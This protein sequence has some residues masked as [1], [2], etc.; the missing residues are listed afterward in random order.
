V[1]FA[2]A[3][4]PAPT[5]VLPAPQGRTAVPEVLHRLLLVRPQRPAVL[6]QLDRVRLAVDVPGEVL[7]RP[8]QLQQRLLDLPALGGVHGDRVRVEA[9]ADQGRDPLR[10]QDLLQHRTVGGGQ[11]QPVRRVLGQREPSVAVH[12]LG[13]VDQ[14]RVRHR[15]AA[16][17]HQRVHDLLGVVT[18]RARVPQA[19]WRHPVGVD[20]LRR[21]LQ[22]RERGDGPTAVVGLLVVDFQEQGLVGLDDQRTIHAWHP[23]PRPDGSDGFERLGQT[24]S[25]PDRRRPEGVICAGPDPLRSY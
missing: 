18:R 16:V 5:S 17:L 24:S 1:D 20:V 9:G 21:P 10:P 11:D 15:I 13:D 23:F 6:G 14:Q 19:Q 3:I 25:V 12:R 2:C 7:G 8:A 4:A 22:L